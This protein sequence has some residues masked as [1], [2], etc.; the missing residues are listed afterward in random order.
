VFFS[1]SAS[2]SAPL[3]RFKTLLGAWLLLFLAGPGI[4]SRDGC[5]LLAFAAL[6][7]WALGASRPGRHAF[8]VEW[9]AASIG[10]CA[11]GF[12]LRHIM[13]AGLLW[14]GP[15]PGL[16][17]AL[18]GVLLRRLVHLL[19]L[20]LAAPLAWLCA[21]TLRTVVDPP[22]GFSW[23]RLGVHLHDVP[24]LAAS[25]RVWG[26]GGLGLIIAGSAGAL[27][28]LIRHPRRSLRTLLPALLF[29]A[30]GLGLGR[31]WGP[32]PM[33][34]G[35]RVMVVQP[36]FEQRRKQ[37]TG[38]PLDLFLD[39]CAL[40]LAGLKE[41]EQHGEPV[42]DLIAWGETMLF[43]PILDPDLPAAW[44][45]GVRPP[46]WSPGGWTRGSL[47]AYIDRERNWVDGV[48]F[49]GAQRDRQV[50]DFLRARGQPWSEAILG[51]ESVVPAGSSFLTGAEYQAV[52][53]GVQ[54]RLNSIFIWD[55][56]GARGAAASKVHLVPGGEQLM[57]L[58]RLAFIR[59]LALDVAG[60]VPDLYPAQQTDVL[61]F[62]G[63][64][65][66]SW[67]VGASICFD[68]AYD[69]PYSAPLRRGPV[70]FHLLVSNEAWYM[71]SWEFDQMVAFSRLEAIATA[72]SFVR[73][74]NGGVSVILD[75]EGRELAR[76]E[77]GGR[78]R[79]VSG[80]LRATV[81]VPAPGQNASRTPWV[82]TEPYWTLL[83]VLA[84]PLLL[85]WA[86]RARRK[87]RNRHE[88]E[89]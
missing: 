11:V 88:T 34:D 14:I 47:E 48:L 36:G 79:Q 80:T 43:L 56:A 70:D 18:G 2:P 3:H 20:A 32:P 6:V 22:L 24:L 52:R 30:A 89:G 21:E 76:L 4:L 74:T 25:A 33:V 66:R 42:P 69:D 77:V 39:S 5:G 23:M 41:A 8:L 55:A 81:P 85:P 10:F 16:Y 46:T 84:A 7:P 53:D 83:W 37:I 68:N 75:P 1:A 82:S 51:G 40:T 13:P 45:R 59:R 72:R 27:A 54:R 86:R 65:G 44:D 28:D 62:A 50:E 49:G 63:R 87:R 67:K 57:G 31:V 61:T 35:P 9:L 12:W 64:D 78:D 38:H 58:E 60:Y 15:L 17:A 29:L 19:P 26:I 73:S 71:D